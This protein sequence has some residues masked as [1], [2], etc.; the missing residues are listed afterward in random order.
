[1]TRV[2]EETLQLGTRQGVLRG[3]AVTGGVITS[4]GVVLA[5]TFAV[6][7]TLPITGLF[8]VGVTVAIGVLLD[9]II[10]R[11]VLV[12]ALSL[13]L[14]RRIWWPSAL[15]RRDES[16]LSEA[17]EPASSSSGSDADAVVVPPRS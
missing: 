3:L 8:Q 14:G 11:S 5:A 16:A 4:A 12:P 15:A 9:A 7:A 17:A 2:R 1:M 6:L 10:V 13:D